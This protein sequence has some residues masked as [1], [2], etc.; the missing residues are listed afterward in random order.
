MTDQHGRHDKSN[1]T[2]EWIDLGLYL[3]VDLRK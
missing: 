1:F 2:L 3:L